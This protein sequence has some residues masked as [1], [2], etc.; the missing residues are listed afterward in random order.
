MFV[1]KFCLKFCKND[2]SL[3]NHER[4]CPNNENRNYKNGMLG[5]TGSNQFI[6]AKKHG[7]KM[8][9]VGNKG[10]PGSFLGKLHTDESKR[11]ISEKL[12]VNNKGGRTKWYEVSGQKVQG[13]WERNIALKFDEIGIIWIKLKTNK[14]ILKYIMN[15]KVKSYTPD[16]YLPQ[17]DIYLEIKGFWWGQDKEKM[18][19]V[20][21]THTDKEIFII[22]KLEYEQI[23]L[24]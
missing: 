7:L 22:E 21:E 12:S 17:F 3:R 8:P 9:T 6:F 16:F 18:K 1:C 19:I 11:K 5:K 20:I 13:T 15:N 4:C 14:D 10:K 23:L 2:N 24:L